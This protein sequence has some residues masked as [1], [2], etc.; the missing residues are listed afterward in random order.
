MVDGKTAEQ[1]M[2]IVLDDKLKKYISKD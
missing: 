2:E 1:R